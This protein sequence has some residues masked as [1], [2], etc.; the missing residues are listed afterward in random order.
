MT[1]KFVATPITVEGFGKTITVIPCNQKHLDYFQSGLLV[2]SC[3]KC[4]FV[5]ATTDPELDRM[6]TK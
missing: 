3:R 6:E 2:V 4:K 5:T 1:T